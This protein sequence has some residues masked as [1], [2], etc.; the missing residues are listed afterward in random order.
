MQECMEA[1]EQA[2]AKLSD[3]E[4]EQRVRSAAHESATQLRADAQ[5]KL[6]HARETTLKVTPSSR[7]SSVPRRC[8]FI[9]ICGR[10][11]RISPCLSV[12]C[13]LQ[14]VKKASAALQEAAQEKAAR[15]AC[16]GERGNRGQPSS[17][18][19]NSAGTGQGAGEQKQRNAVKAMLEKIK[20][21]S[22]PAGTADLV[23]R[24]GGSL[25]DLG[26][27]V[28]EDGTVLEAP[29]GL[30]DK[31]YTVVAIDGKRFSTAPRGRREG[32]HS[33]VQK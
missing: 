7:R 11:G 3:A 12:L 20:A 22:S 33:A 13:A 16:E 23:I 24:I 26:I 9:T 5:A 8:V 10:K 27:K 17:A 30:F 31:D 2:Q 15:D 4:L 29:S 32:R 28:D 14:E 18:G 6:Q 1:Q 21:A 19:V 25:E